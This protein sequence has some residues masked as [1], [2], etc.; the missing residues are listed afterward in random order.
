MSLAFVFPGQGAQSVGMGRDLAQAYP[1]CQAVFDEV[2][3]K[4]DEDDFFLEDDPF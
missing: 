3:L 2:E 1:E 4:G